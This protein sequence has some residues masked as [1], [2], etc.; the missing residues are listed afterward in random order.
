MIENIRGA[1]LQDCPFLYEIALKTANAGVD[2]SSLFNNPYTVGYYYSAPYL[3]FEHKLCFVALDSSHKPSGYIVGTSNTVLY[4]S[5][6]NTNWL[7]QI[8]KMY[9]VATPKSENEERIIK[10][11]LKGQ[12]QGFWEHSGYP[13]HLHINLLP[14]LQGK[15]LGRGLIESFI[16]QLIEL[17]VQGV[18]LGVDGKNE[19]A[20]GFYKTLGFKILEETEW[21]YFMG[22]KF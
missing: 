17:K 7:P 11:I 2:A 20:I 14:S 21:G 12:G 19:N 9:K 3:H 5:W 18:H 1:T 22:I 8:Q 10:Q 16:S 13:A 6:L 4:N 15:G